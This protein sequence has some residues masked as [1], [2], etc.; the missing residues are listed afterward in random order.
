MREEEEPEWAGISICV[1]ELKGGGM[2]RLSTTE[3]E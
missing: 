2:E 1:A 3:F